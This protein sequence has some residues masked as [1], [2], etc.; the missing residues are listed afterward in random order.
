MQD[1]Q[2]QQAASYLL[3]RRHAKQTGPRLEPALQPQTNEEAFAIQRAVMDGMG[4]SVGGWKCLLP[5]AEKLIAAPIFT[6]SIYSSSPCPIELDLGRCR[7]EPEIAFTFKQDLPARKAEYSEDEIITVL[8]SA[9]LALELILNR[10]LPTEKASHFD[11]LADCLVN[12]GMYIGPEIELAEAMQ[13]SEFTLTF[14]QRQSDGQLRVDKFPAKHP[15]IYPHLPL[16]WLVNFLSQ[17]GIAIKAGQKII[18]GSYAG[19]IE[20]LPNEEF[21][22]EYEGLGRIQVVLAAQ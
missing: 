12:Q 10:F 16:L 6:S 18:T 11:N 15:N 14:S 2:I 21:T 17:R 7:I 19:V 8:G 20:V 3:K 13:A 9:H 5:I 1:Q 22:L 4:D